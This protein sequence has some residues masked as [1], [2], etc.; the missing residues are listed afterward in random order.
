MA[1]AE[2]SDP[3]RRGLIIAAVA[4]A[5][6]RVGVACLG[7]E[8]G[9]VK[10]P[11]QEGQKF[12]EVRLESIGGLGAH[13]AGMLL[14]E[15]GVLGMGLNGAHFSSYGSEKKGTPVRS[16]VR[17][18][19]PEVEVRTSS[20]V[21]RPNVVAIFHEALVRTLPVLSGL[22]PGGTV[23]VNTTRAPL[24]EAER[25]GIPRGA[26]VGTVDA[27]GIAVEENTR[28]N[29]AMLGALTRVCSFIDPEAVKERIRVFFGGKYPALVEANVRTFQR[30]YE[31]LE[32]ERVLEGPEPSG[33]YVRPESPFGYLTQ[34]TG[35]VVPAATTVA[36]DL[37]ASREGWLPEFVREECIDCAKCDMVCPDFCFVW[38]KQTDAKGRTQ[39]V[40]LGIDYK[41]CKGCLKC[42][43]AC[44]TDALAKR[45]EEEGW[46]EAHRVPHRW[47]PVA[48][49]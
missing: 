40:L 5:G 47:E 6:W 33:K 42:I 29:T 34:W 1:G 43:E 39:M 30:G 41:Y 20:P 14:A 21:D 35:G 26:Y 48:V 12:F 28:V 2:V 46:A 27:L 11:F 7:G 38:E 10:L 4:P 3:I 18:T 31:E 19:Y 16:F 13:L 15:A 49:G 22:L 17:F 36:R 32:L 24:E 37:S 25:L 45:R 44:P 23:V 9:T 8:M